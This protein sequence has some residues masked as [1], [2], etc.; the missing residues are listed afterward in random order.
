MTHRHCWLTYGAAHQKGWGREFA[1]EVNF[2]GFFLSFFLFWHIRAFCSAFKGHLIK[3]DQGIQIL[4]LKKDQ[5]SLLFSLL[6]FECFHLYLRKSTAASP[7]FPCASNKHHVPCTSWPK[8]AYMVIKFQLFY[9]TSHTQHFQSSFLK[10]ANTDFDT[11]VCLYVCFPDACPRSF[12]ETN[13]IKSQWPPWVLSDTD[14]SGAHG[15]VS[16]WCTAIELWYSWPKNSLV[17]SWS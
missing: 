7:P 17:D 15:Q 14:H 16:F 5:N 6:F 2:E 10:T 9:P 3:I 13:C 4:Q 11:S 1:G 8:I 12:P